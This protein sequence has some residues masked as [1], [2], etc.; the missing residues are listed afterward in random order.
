MEFDLSD[1]DGKINFF[2]YCRDHAVREGLP[3]SGKRLKDLF[4]LAGETA[5][6]GLNDDQIY[7]FIPPCRIE[8]LVKKAKNN[9]GRPPIPPLRLVKNG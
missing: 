9:M 1:D 8:E 5:P 6:D 7:N 2:I 3:L 4:A